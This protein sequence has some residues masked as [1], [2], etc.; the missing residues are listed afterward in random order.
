VG[1]LEQRGR[2]SKVAGKSQEIGFFKVLQ[3][4]PCLWKESKQE[5]TNKEGI[6]EVK[7][8]FMLRKG[9]VYLFSREER[10]EVHELIEE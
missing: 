1:N 9:K 6:M 8:G 3:I 7:K 10:G 4:D 2:S 5:D